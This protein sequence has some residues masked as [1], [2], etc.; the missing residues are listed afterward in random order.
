MVDYKNI[1]VEKESNIA[2]VSI[3]RPSALNA[4]NTEVLTEIKQSM[5]DLEQDK[6]VKV[7]ILT[8]VGE[9]SFVAGADIGEMVSKNPVEGEQFALAG[10]AAF[11][12]IEQLKKP[13]IA[14]VNG[15]ALGGGCELAMACDIRV[16]SEKAKFG[17]PEVGLGII[18]GFG[19]TQRLLRLVGMGMAKMLIMSCRIIDGKE[20]L[21]V[22][23]ADILTSS[24][25]LLPEAKKLATE[26]ASKSF[27]AVCLSKET[28]N[29]GYELGL[30]ASIDFEA[31]K[32]GECFA[33][34]EQKE[35]MTAFLE[36]R[37][38]KY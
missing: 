17:Q 23:L 38:P 8:G 2:I 6:D 4:L 1:L 11:A 34:P 9:K 30:K 21:R 25:E 29:A 22:G 33:N 36:K 3:N 16:V 7:I 35:G 12:T 15:F 18:P 14:A 24:E 5:K 13:V 26:I 31:K 32:F 19:G 27:N 10:Q 37:P 28:I 20:A